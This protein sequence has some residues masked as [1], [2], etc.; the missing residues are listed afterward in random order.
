MAVKV[1]YPGVDTALEEDLKNAGALVRALG[2]GGALLDGKAYFDELKREVGAELD[3]RRELEHLEQFRSLLARWPDLVVP[4][5]FPAL[6]T[7][8]VLVLEELEGPTLG[9]LAQ[10]AD[11]VPAAQRFAIGERLMRAIYGPFLFNRVVHADVHPGN[12]VV[13]SGDR[14]G[15]LD[16]GS[17]KVLSERFWRCY[18]TA[19]AS[20]VSGRPIDLLPLLREG[21]FEVGLPDD[22]A[23]ELLDA[24]CQIVGAPVS[25]P[26]D[27]GGDQMISRLVAL[28]RAHTFDL[29][30]IRPPAE[31]LLFWR[32]MG[33][34][35]HN[36][37]A[38]KASGD[39][40]PFL[41]ESLRELGM[42]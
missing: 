5:G 2:I 10:R 13:M 30:R 22:R 36:L 35:S 11:H 1:Q 38:L 23:R 9:E 6:S 24:I 16:Y 7:G 12:F 28:K 17:V 3:Y 4:K 34:L 21:G 20:G 39:F 8:K 32:A 29:M 15:V 18:L 26:H 40:R 31:A 41:R 25:A 33:G 27:F 37:R 19:L 14:L 42:L